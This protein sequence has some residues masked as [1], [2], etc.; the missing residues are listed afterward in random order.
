MVGSNNKLRD[1]DI[2]WCRAAWAWGLY[3]Q[4][5]LKS[6][7]GFW[8]KLSWL[9][10]PLRA[11]MTSLTDCFVYVG[12]GGLFAIFAINPVELGDAFLAGITWPAALTLLLGSQSQKETL[13]PRPS[14]NERGIA[15]QTE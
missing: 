12:L 7:K 6:T 14:R 1:N 9:G 3:R 8:A 2:Y 5:G 11:I 15:A 4:A 10:T 13:P